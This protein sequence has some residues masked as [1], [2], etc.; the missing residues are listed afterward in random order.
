[1]LQLVTTSTTNTNTTFGDL[2]RKTVIKPINRIRRVQKVGGKMIGI[3]NSEVSPALTIDD[4][5]Q[6]TVV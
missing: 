5:S 1:L 2:N 6:A 3:V 4:K